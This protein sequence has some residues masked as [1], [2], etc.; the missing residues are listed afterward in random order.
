MVYK[1]NTFN[2]VRVS[3]IICSSKKRQHIGRKH[4]F[5]TQHLRYIVNDVDA[6][7]SSS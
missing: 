5:S 3:K 2:F 7:K 4:A 6:T 1:I